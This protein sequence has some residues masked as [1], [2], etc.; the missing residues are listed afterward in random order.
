MSQET[1]RVLV[2]DDVDAAP[3]ADLGPRIQAHVRFPDQVN[4]GFM[5]VIDR[6]RVRLRV[7][8]RGAG[9]SFEIAGRF[10]IGVEQR[11]EFRAT[12][13]VVSAGHVEEG[14]A[15]L[16]RQRQRLRKQRFQFVPA[17]RVHGTI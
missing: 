8:E 15:L 7:Y 6:G 14:G 13:R 2:V 16:V 3:V 1:A 17:G 10:V 11:R 9:E 4:V 12:C 5:Q